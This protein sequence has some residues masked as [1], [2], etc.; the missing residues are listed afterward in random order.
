MPARQRGGGP[1]R[2]LAARRALR[3]TTAGIVALAPGPAFAHN[4]GNLSDC[5]QI[6]MA[7][8]LAGLGISVLVFFLPELLRL[9][10]DLSVRDHPDNVVGTAAIGKPEASISP[11]IEPIIDTTAALVEEETWGYAPPHRAAT[12]VNPNEITTAID[13][14]LMQEGVQ[15]IGKYTYCNRAAV[16]IL[17][18]LG[19]ADDRLHPVVDPNKENALVFLT[20]TRYVLGEKGE[21]KLVFSDVEWTRAN[22][23]FSNLERALQDKEKPA[24]FEQLTPAQAQER[25]NRGYV[26]IAAFREDTPGLSGH[27]AIVAPDAEAYDFKKGPRVGGAGS[28]SVMGF[29]YAKDVFYDGDYKYDDNG[30]KIYDKHGDPEIKLKPA[31]EDGDLLRY[32]Q[33]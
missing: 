17:K 9:G 7:A 13:K 24:H 21:S 10:L 2:D 27:V 18:E 4:C 26:V 32:Y 16:R 6:P 28:P 29:H 3:L 19:V 12:H 15:P 30:N 22:D 1:M 25:A 11:A 14:V 5:Y 31:F 23:I 8:A 20:D 33:L